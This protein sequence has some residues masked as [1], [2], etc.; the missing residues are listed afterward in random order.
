MR[1]GAGLE[2]QSNEAIVREWVE[3]GLNGDDLTVVDKHFAPDYRLTGPGVEVVGREAFKGFAGMWRTAFPDVRFSLA[4]L[5]AGGDKV[6]WRFVIA[7]TQEGEI[8]GVP[9]TQRPVN[10]EVIVISRFANGKW[11]E[12]HVVFDM[13]GMLQQLGAIPAPEAT[14]A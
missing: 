11:V 6:A 3:A 12:D 7:G 1:G 13:F 4:E 10:V 2:T 9:P 14:A 5:V 8:F